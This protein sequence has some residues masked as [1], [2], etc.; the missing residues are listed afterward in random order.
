MVLALEGKHLEGMSLL[1]T[2]HHP[3]YNACNRELNLS[4][5]MLPSPSGLLNKMK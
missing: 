2:C 4:L 5:P 1:R 3:E